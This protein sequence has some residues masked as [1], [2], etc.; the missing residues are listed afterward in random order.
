MDRFKVLEK[1][2]FF[3]RQDAKAPR[4]G[5]R[6][7]REINPYLYFA[8]WRFKNAIILAKVRETTTSG[9]KFPW[10]RRNYFGL[11]RVFSGIIQIIVG[12]ICRHGWIL[13]I[14]GR[15]FAPAF[16]GTIY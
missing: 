16:C 2:V 8:S 3:N 11:T 5:Q 14:R 13:G 12:K 9:R 7:C 15:I 1:W 4:L 6:R 10:L